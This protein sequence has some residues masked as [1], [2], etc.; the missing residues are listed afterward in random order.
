L[1][2]N[3]A[4]S[5]GIGFYLIEFFASFLF[6]TFSS[7]FPSFVQTPA[8]AFILQIKVERFTGVYLSADSF[9]VCIPSQKKGISIKLQIAPELFATPYINSLLS[10]Y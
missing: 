9:L 2:P 7:T 10:Y 5:T 3:E 8:L 6:P 4:S 1:S